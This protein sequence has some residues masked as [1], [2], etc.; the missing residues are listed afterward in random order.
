M[1]YKLGTPA[2]LRQLPPL[3]AGIYNILFEQVKILSDGYGTSRNID[4]DDGGY[5]LYATPGAPVE[6]IK[7][8]FDYS[9]V[10]AEYVTLDSS[11][12]PAICKALYIINNEFSVMIVMSLAD[13]PPE[14]IKEI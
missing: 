3:D 12:E 5:I 2:D 7:A 6:D 14:I 8:I 11:V 1:V 4:T 10:R 13:A 9:A